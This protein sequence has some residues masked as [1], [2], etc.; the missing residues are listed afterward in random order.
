MVRT[1][2]DVTPTVDPVPTRIATPQAP[3][4]YAPDPEAY[5][6]Y[7]SALAVEPTPQPTTVNAGQPIWYINNGRLTIDMAAFDRSTRE[8]MQVVLYDLSGHM[9]VRWNGNQ[10][11]SQT[12][13]MVPIGRQGLER[14]AYIMHVYGAGM[15][16]T[17]RVVVW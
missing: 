6:D 5:M 12:R 10:I 15:M 11:A 2:S 4:I 1:L 9:V 3:T 14:G 13:L 16:L 17:K 8:H 7:E